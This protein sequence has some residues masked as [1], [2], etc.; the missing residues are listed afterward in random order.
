MT[1]TVLNPDSVFNT[2]QYGFSQAAIVSGQRRMLL[3]GQVGVDACERTVGP[4]LR[5]QTE[6]AFDNIERVLAA[7]GA[8]LEQV[9]MLRIYICEAAREEQDVIVAALRQRFPNDP[10]PSSWIIVSGLSLPEWL[11]EIEAEAVLD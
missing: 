8:G 2:R 11:I 10:P 7:A 5:E 4:G 9:V 6:A 1:K 3:S